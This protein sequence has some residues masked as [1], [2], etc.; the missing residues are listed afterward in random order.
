MILRIYRRRR[1]PKYA[2]ADVP[3]IPYAVCG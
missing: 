3:T 1:L 2:A